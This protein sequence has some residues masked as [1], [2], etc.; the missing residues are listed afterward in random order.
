MSTGLKRSLAEAKRD[1][2]DFRDMFTGR[3]DQWEIAG[4]VRRGKPEVGDIEHVVIPI[5]GLVFARMDELLPKD[6]GALFGGSSTIEKAVYPDGRH[7]WGPKYRGV[8]F[9]GFRHE[10]FLCSR[11]NWGSIFAIR[12]GPAEFSQ[13]C[14]TELHKYGLRQH[15][16]RIINATN[17]IFETPTEERFFE[18]CGMP[19]IE[20]KERA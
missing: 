8:M 4:S 10:V 6:D 14:V 19:W 11:H 5:G 7:R 12:T 3:Y 15:K 17:D 20:P 9:R 16:G 18:L 2:I 13:R 1:A